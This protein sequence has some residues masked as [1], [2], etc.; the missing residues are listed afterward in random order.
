VLLHP[1]AVLHTRVNGAV[2]SS[3]ALGAVLAFF[4]LYITILVASTLAATALGNDKLNMMTALSGA[5]ATLVNVGPG[6]GNL[7]AVE[8]YYWL[9]AGVKWVFSFC[10]LAGRLELYSVLLLFHPAIWTR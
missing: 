7:G 1:R 2:V 10:M 9:P 8:N 4:T 3:R 6:L 5:T